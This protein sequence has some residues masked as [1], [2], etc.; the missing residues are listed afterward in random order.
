M[1]HYRLNNKDGYFTYHYSM[2]QFKEEVYGL[3][4][5]ALD[6]LKNRNQIVSELK[7]NKECHNV[8]FINKLK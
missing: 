3:D 5:N 8:L 1:Q 6:L 7:N 4:T 2:S